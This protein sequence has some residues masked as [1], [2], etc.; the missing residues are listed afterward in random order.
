M[1][2]YQKAKAIWYFFT[3]PGDE[4]FKGLWGNNI[5]APEE[6]LA[7]K[8]AAAEA[9]DPALVIIALILCYFYMLG[10]KNA[11]KGIYWLLG[12]YTIYTLVVSSL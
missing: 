10:A 8:D 1:F 2:I 6:H 7:L 11:G 3:T 9:L 12:L 4:I 5:P